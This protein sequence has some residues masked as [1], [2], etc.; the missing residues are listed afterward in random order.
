MLQLFPVPEWKLDC[1]TCDFVI[2]L[3]PS[4]QQMNVVWV[5]VD[6]LTKLVHFILINM[7]YPVSTLAR[8]YKGQIVR[9]G[10]FTSSLWRSFQIELGMNPRFSTAYH[11]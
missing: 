3:T 6:R 5:I 2:H 10:S 4:R 1:I 8:L 11:L 9:T 7:T